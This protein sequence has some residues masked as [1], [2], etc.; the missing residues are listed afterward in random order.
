MR[1][2]TGALAAVLL[3]GGCTLVIDVDGPLPDSGAAPS[4][5]AAPAPTDGAATP[6]AAPRPDAAPPRP[7]ATPDAAP[8]R[9]D[10]AP[11]RPDATPDAAPPR[12]DA[13]PPPDAAP[14]PCAPGGCEWAPGPWSDCPVTCGE[15]QQRRDVQCVDAAGAEVSADRCAEPRP[16]RVRTVDCTVPEARAVCVDEAVW[17]ADGCD[18]P[19]REWIDCAIRGGCRDGS[20]LCSEKPRLHICCWTVAQHT[21]YAGCLEIEAAT[22]RQRICPNGPDDVDPGWAAEN[23]QSP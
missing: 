11:P 14:D 9:P 7:D 5:D 19:V 20:C 13:A 16:E 10:A 2:T 3:G 15:G 12:P 17:W 6:D 21:R 4:A 22:I 23:C 1:R 18:E 8:P